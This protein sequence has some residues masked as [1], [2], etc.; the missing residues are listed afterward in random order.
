MTQ[1]D[2]NKTHT[3]KIITSPPMGKDDDMRDSAQPNG[4][5]MVNPEGG[6]AIVLET[7]EKG[8]ESDSLDTLKKAYDENMLS[9]YSLVVIPDPPPLSPPTP[10]GP[11]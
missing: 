2:V 11:S 8:M 5:T 4:N 10:Q 7:I 9:N 6:A 1:R 3:E